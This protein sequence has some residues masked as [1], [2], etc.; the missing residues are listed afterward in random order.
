MKVINTK[1]KNTY[2]EFDNGFNATFYTKDIFHVQGKKGGIVKPNTPN[3]I[4][5]KQAVDA[6]LEQANV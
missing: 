6:F 2:F 1:F 4:K 5:A 3:W